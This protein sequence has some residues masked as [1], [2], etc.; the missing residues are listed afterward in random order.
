[1]HHCPEMVVI[2]MLFLRSLATNEVLLSSNAE[3]VLFLQSLA[4]NKVLLLE[5]YE[6][7]S[8]G[9]GLTMCRIFSLT[10]L[11]NFFINFNCNPS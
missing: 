8:G 5:M 11:F 10:G 7:C 1:M 4:N 6:L 3:L 2:L 9:T